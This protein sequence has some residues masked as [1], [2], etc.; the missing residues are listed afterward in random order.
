MRHQDYIDEIEFMRV[1]RT[2][3]LVGG[4]VTVAYFL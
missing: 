2:L 4:I 3:R 1:R